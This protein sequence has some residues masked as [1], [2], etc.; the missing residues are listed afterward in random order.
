M[1]SYVL[2]NKFYTDLNPVDFGYEYCKPGKSF[3]PYIR[4]YYLLH[5]VVSGNGV[6]YADDTWYPVSA[7]QF[8]V[9]RPREVTTYVADTKTPW[10]YIWI[11]F[12]GNAAKHWVLLQERVVDYGGD[13][14]RDMLQAEQFSDG[15]EEFLI[16]KLFQLMAAYSATEPSMNRYVSATKNYITSNYMH[17]FTLEEIAQS[18]GIDRSYLSKLF[19][20]QT[21]KTFRQVLLETRMQKAREFLKNGYSVEETALLCGYQ[22]A[23]SFSRA[24]KKQFHQPPKTL[25]S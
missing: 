8:F 11:G 2:Q 16:A 12:E 10:H 13:L 21:H 17:S 19:K 14:F 25:K 4:D 20:A 5:F 3:G 7:N 9:I 23:C 15:K 22:E 24:F 1:G 18:M 6:L